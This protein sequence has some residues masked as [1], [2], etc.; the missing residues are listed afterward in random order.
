MHQ[1]L[2]LLKISLDDFLTL[3]NLRDL[4][5]FDSITHMNLVLMIEGQVNRIL[6][7]DEM[8]GILNPHNLRAL[9]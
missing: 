1:V 5:Q 4:E 7:A 8:L 2:E 6:T 3:G 9:L